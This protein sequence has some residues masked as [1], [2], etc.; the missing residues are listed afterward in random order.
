MKEE[1]AR[2]MRLVKEGKLSP[3]DAAELIDAMQGSTAE[4][5]REEEPVH[6]AVGDREQT[7]PPPPPPPPPP[8]E[9]GFH[10]LIDAIEK[11][12]KEVTSS[13]NWT[14]VG[15]Q[16]RKGVKQGAEV[17]KKAASDIKD[18]KVTFGLYETEARK[19]ELPL[20]VAEGKLL[21][22]ESVHG[23]V[24][25]TCG[26]PGEGRL[27]A[28]AVFK[29]DDREAL[30]QRAEEFSVVI[31]ESEH[32]VLIRQPDQA[33]LTVDFE[34]TLP[35]GVAVETRNDNG[36]TYLQGIRGQ[37]RVSSQNGDI[38]VKDAEGSLQ[39]SNANGSTSLVSAKLGHLSVEA[40]N[41]DVRMEDV[42][43]PMAITTAS[44]DVSLVRCSGKSL[45]VD[46]V[47][48]DIRVDWIEPLDGAAN[49]RTVNGFVSVDIADGSSL[50]VKLSALRGTVNCMVPLQDEVRADRTITGRMG[51]GVGTLDISAING[52]LYLRL[53]D[54]SVS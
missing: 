7:S 27:I 2:I 41:G 32:F 23:D 53:R 54:S 14:E 3:E 22:V 28:H 12:G 52:D 21:R 4:E 44:G 15:D 51:E 35:E 46:G 13:I 16:L 34:I 10:S 45:S 18:G 48:G 50:R 49:I 24:R 39:L 6:S 26:Q 33:G 5:V 29:G 11:V 47:S 17:I 20:A 30:R 37:S 8:K 19:V 31:E 40:K 25:V 1:M 9:G 42:Q 38:H 43:A 36:E